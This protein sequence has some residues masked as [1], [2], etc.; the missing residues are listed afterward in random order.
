MA[1]VWAGG[2]GDD[3]VEPEPTTITV[4]PAAATLLSVGETV[5]LSATVQ[6]Q[7]GEIMTDVAVTWTSRDTKVSMVDGNGLVTAAGNG[8]VTVE[9]SAGTAAGLAS[10]TV[11]Q[12]PAEVR[13]SPE[14]VTLVSFGEAVQLSAEALDA[15]GH[16]IEDADFTWSSD[17][18][19]VAT[20]DGT[21]V[22]VAIGNGVATIEVSADGA[23]GTSEIIVEQ[24]L[25][26]VILSPDTA[27]LAEIGDTV[28]IAAE[29][30]DANGNVIEGV[31]FTWSSSDES[32]VTVDATGLV[33]ANGNGVAEV[34]AAVETLAAAAIIRVELHRRL[35]LRFFEAMGGSE[36]NNSQ[37]WG[38]DTPIGTWHGVTTDAAGKVTRLELR[39]NNL[40]DSLPAEIGMLETLAVLYLDGNSIAGPIP[41]ELGNL[42]SMRAIILWRNQLTGEIP[43]ELGKLENLWQLILRDNRLTGEIPP[44]LGKLKMMDQMDLSDNQLTGS[45]PP[46]LGNME[47]LEDVYFDNNQLTGSIPPEFGN[48]ENLYLLYVHDNEGMSGP[49]PLELTSL[50]LDEFYWYST[51][52]CAPLDEDFQEW[53]ESISDNQGEENCEEDSPNPGTRSRPSPAGDSELQDQ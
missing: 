12:R 30:A 47:Y 16:M 51:D 27:I 50:Y 20:V 45:I 2:C 52:L 10:I 24:R 53:L 32:T 1:I 31:E 43:P 3:P 18:E 44:E 28:R 5:Q 13:V 40:T 41:P 37:N 36:W 11:D 26:E 34:E 49:L 8:T 19:S 22:V 4:S 38:T 39:D 46:E 48:L 17:D 14:A 33:T 29:A 9:A 25:A 21:G 6:D 7:N 15:N 23:A 42:R 35:L